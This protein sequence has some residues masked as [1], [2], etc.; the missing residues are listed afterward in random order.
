M[1]ASTSVATANDLRQQLRDGTASLHRRLESALDMLTPPLQRG[2]YLRLLQRFHG[3]HALWEPSLTAWLAPDFRAHRCKLPLL[4]QDLLAL[5]MVDAAIDALP[6][7]RNAT[8]LSST[9]EAAL[10][11]LYV[12]EGSTLGGKMISS[13][14]LGAAWCPQAGLR[15][16][17]PYGNETGRRWSETLRCLSEAAPSASPAILLGAQQTFGLLQ[18][19]L[20]GI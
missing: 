5:G 20:T 7:C 2:H 19:W 13:H 6:V 1:I 18:V 17:N 4:R 10:G 16:F 9:R 12:I 3:F 8:A 14:L 11:A 15:Y